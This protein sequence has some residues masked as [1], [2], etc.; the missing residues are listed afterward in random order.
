MATTE[1]IGVTGTRASCLGVHSPTATT[2]DDAA[3]VAFNVDANP[4]LAALSPNFLAH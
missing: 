3:V 4:A 2:H 1:E